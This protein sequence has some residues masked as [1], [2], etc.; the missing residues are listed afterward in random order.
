[1]NKGEL[2]ERLAEAT[3]KTKADSERTLNALVHIIVAAVANGESVRL[4]DF[5]TFQTAT[6]KARRVH[7]PAT[8]QMI[9]LPA[10]VRPRFKPARAFVG[11][12]QDLAP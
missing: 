12:V 10:A 4:V 3:G 8:R 5:G 6:T 2:I 1:M 9:D 11:T 7:N